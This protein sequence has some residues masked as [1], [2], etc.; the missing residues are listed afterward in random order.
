MNESEING[1]YLEILVEAFKENKEISCYGQILRVDKN[2][3]GT[4]VATF[5]KESNQNF[6][7]NERLIKEAIKN[8]RI[9]L[10]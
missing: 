5:L 10:I 7:E 8:D 9:K 4:L 6:G 3:N 1:K 2:E